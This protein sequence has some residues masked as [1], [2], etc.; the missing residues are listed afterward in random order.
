[1][2]SVLV[3]DDEKSIRDSIRRILEYEKF[4]VHF[5]EDGP[6]TISQVAGYPFDLVLLDIKMPGMD[7]LEVL[8]KVTDDW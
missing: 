6:S 1:M 8:Q 3:V 2:K 7:G 4:E 5:A